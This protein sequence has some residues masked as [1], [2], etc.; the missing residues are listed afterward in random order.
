MTQALSDLSRL[1]I[2]TMT[3]KPWSLE[4]SIAAYTRLVHGENPTY[5][6]WNNRGVAYR[7]KG[8][9]KRARKDIVQASELDSSKPEPFNNLGLIYLDGESY[10]HAVSS[11]L[12]A[13]E[14]DPSFL[15]ATLNATVVYG[16]YLDDMEQATAYL[17]QYVD[18]GGTLQREMFRR[19]LAGGGRDEEGQGPAS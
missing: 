2:H 1:C 9:M 19:W 11:F 3:T 6:D 7:R 13:L 14:I 10:E 5:G 15:P 18:K 12:R 17:R 8:D 4:E 16:Q